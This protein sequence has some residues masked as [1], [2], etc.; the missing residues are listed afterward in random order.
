M[1]A[2]DIV[3]DALH[4]IGAIGLDDQ[5]VPRE[6][7]ICLS[8]MNAMLEQWSAQ[9]LI[10]RASTVQ[11]L[12]LTANK[13]S[14]TIGTGGELNTVKPISIQS[15][16]VRDLSN[17]DHRVDI[18]TVEQYDNFE[19]KTVSS[20][21]P[22]YLAYD[23]GV[24]QQA[25]QLGTIYLYPIPDMAYTL[26]LHSFKA[27][28]DFTTITDNVTFEPM[29]NEALVY[30]LATRIWRKFKPLETSIPQDILYLAEESLRTIQKIVSTTPPASCDIP[31]VKRDNS[32]N[33]L[34]D[35]F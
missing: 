5:P 25:A 34:S 7:S 26:H 16:Y 28:T 8:S 33:I 19:D 4:I 18:C 1:I 35:T 6:I 11:D 3:K 15:C 21:V 23:P 29:Y 31:G 24:T 27:L 20:S 9:K 14:Y 13:A 30:N 10:V 2:R 12:A 32:Y 22:E 17:V